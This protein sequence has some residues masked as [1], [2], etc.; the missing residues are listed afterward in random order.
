MSALRAC[1]NL[2]MT[3][4]GWPGADIPVED[5]EKVAD[6]MHEHGCVPVFL[7]RE[8]IDLYYNGFSNGVLWPLLHYVSHSYSSGSSEKE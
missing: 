5:Q 3:Q 1:E 8:E 6:Q 4:V 7:S 2:H